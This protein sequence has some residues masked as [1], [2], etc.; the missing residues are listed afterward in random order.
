MRWQHWLVMAST[1]GCTTGSGSR[2]V[3]ETFALGAL[4]RPTEDPRDTAR[5]D[6]GLA[7]PVTRAQI[8]AL[9]VARD[10]GLRALVHEARAALHAARA[11]G[12]LPPPELNAQ[13]WNLPLARP[14]ALGE[15]GMYMVEARQMFPAAGSR[16]ARARAAAEEARERVAALG[17]RESE[18]LSQ[19]GQAY[20][21]YLHGA[22]EHRVH[23][24]HLGLLDAMLGAARARFA[25][26]GPLA[27]VPRIES[28]QARTH[29]A[30]TRID[31]ELERA[32]AALNTLLRREADAP[33]GPPADLAPETVQLP[34][35]DL[36][37]LAARARSELGQA[38]ARIRSAAARSDA[39]RAESRW[40]TF[41]GAL[42]YWQDPMLRPGVGA[43][44]AATLP[45]VW[46]GAAERV[47]EAR[48]RELAEAASADRVTVTVRSEVAVARARLEGLSR[49]LTVLRRE[50]RPAAA[51]AETAVRVSYVAG[52]GDLLAWIDAARQVL[53]VETEE[54]DV[55]S[56]M[57]HA[58]TDLEQAVGAA[59]PRVAVET[60]ALP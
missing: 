45:W 23:A 17:A 27:D 59:L 26:G 13:V 30:M 2:M 58:A 15:A 7:G 56:A 48:E 9:A 53:D 38:R 52:R 6:A 34:L 47:A 55:T 60:D 49:E 31:S 12:A 4:R 18:V 25:S 29:R 54:A 24:N 32:R 44:V 57:A 51:R 43:T 41:T 37:A 46:G 11:E 14:Y 42:S 21:D 28:E 3:D 1:A 10:A 40:P 5:E 39:A 33:F 20:A 22:L 35:A 19:A 50:A 8:L 16:D 36:L